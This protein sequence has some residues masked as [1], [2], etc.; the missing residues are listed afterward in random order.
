LPKTGFKAPIHRAAAA[1]FAACCRCRSV[2]SSTLEDRERAT[3][4]WPK[5]FA[6]PMN[7]MWTY[8]SQC[9]VLLAHAEQQPGTPSHERYARKAWNPV[10]VWHI[11]LYQYVDRQKDHPERIHHTGYK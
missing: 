1:G 3:P 2:Q 5:P 9:C 10:L 8:R 7:R 11:L 4:F 6:P